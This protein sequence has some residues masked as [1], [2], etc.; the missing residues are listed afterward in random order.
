MT[1]DIIRN[2][3]ELAQLWP[4]LADALARDHA[5]EHGERIAAAGSTEP[6]LPVN[7]DVA[8][9]IDYLTRNIAA[10]A[11]YARHLLDEPAWTHSVPVLLAWDIT[12]WHGRLVD[13][14][15]TVHAEHLAAAV[16]DWLGRT[17]AALGFTTPDRHLGAMCPEHDQPLVELVEPGGSATLHTS[18]AGYRITWT[19]VRAIKCRYCRA[20]WTPGPDYLALDRALNR[21]DRRR[22]GHIP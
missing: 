3:A 18:P 17:R 19:K 7:L 11:T 14:G 20:T 8:D 9:A 16:A 12:R 1:S 4:A 2:T 5:P 15:D 10:A 6:G 21:A 22:A 13:L